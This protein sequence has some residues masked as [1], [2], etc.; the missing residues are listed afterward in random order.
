MHKYSAYNIPA[1]ALSILEA[2]ENQGFIA[3]GYARWVA[4][5]FKSYSPSDIDIFHYRQNM[6]YNPVDQDEFELDD[7]VVDSLRKLG[8]EITRDLPNAIEMKMCG[9]V[10]I[11]KKEYYSIVNHNLRTTGGPFYYKRKPLANYT[12]V[13]VIKPFTNHIPAF[14]QY[15]TEENHMGSLNSKCVPHPQRLAMKTFG[16][17]SEVISLFDFPQAM[18]AMEWRTWKEPHSSAISNIIITTDERF[19][20]AEDSKK[21]EICHINCPIAVAMR[22]FKYVGKGYTI[23]P[24][25]IIKLSSTGIIVLLSTRIDWLNYVRRII[26]KLPSGLNLSSC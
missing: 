18:V 26:L 4:T 24:R 2:I 23:R 6:Q 9:L 16:T 20:G 15:E 21:L 19:Q 7:P 25:E 13:Q 14:K 3:G 11:T 1:E 17:P 22:A 12:T 10:E 8:Y 5:D